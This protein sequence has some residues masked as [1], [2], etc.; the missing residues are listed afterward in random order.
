[1]NRVIFITQKNSV[2]T[3]VKFH[4]EIAIKVE[5]KSIKNVVIPFSKPKSIHTRNEERKNRE[6]GQTLN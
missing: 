5:V 3:K 4:K 1:M 6:K 2:V